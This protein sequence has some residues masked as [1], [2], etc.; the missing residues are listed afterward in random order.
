MGKDEIL[1]IMA[2]AKPTMSL[3][4]SL[5]DGRVLKVKDYENGQLK[6]ELNVA[7]YV[8]YDCFLSGGDSDH[9]ITLA[10]REQQYPGGQQ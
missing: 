3:P 7:P 5:G 9:V 2:W 8:I 4:I 6:F 1:Q 10:P